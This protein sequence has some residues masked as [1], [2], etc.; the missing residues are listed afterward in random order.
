[1]HA[2]A[3]CLVDASSGAT[4]PANQVESWRNDTGLKTQ[5]DMSSLLPV[6]HSFPTLP[7]LQV[8]EW[9]SGLAEI[10]G[11]RAVL[12]AESHCGCRPVFK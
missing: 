4:Y 2:I 9:V 7:R 12:P 3:N 5:Y 8:V 11:I 1:M 6:V 10:R